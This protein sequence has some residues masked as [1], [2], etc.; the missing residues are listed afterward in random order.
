MRR[1]SPSGRRAERRDDNKAMARRLARKPDTEWDPRGSCAGVGV[2]VARPRTNSKADERRRR[3]AKTNG[4]RGRKSDGEAGRGR[5]RR[6]VLQR[7]CEPRMNARNDLDDELWLFD[8][9]RLVPP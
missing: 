1:D 6:A 8:T 5:D 2:G 7:G 9:T 4:A 3:V